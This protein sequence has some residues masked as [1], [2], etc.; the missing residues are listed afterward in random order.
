VFLPDT[1]STSGAK[2]SLVQLAGSPVLL[3]QEQPFVWPVKGTSRVAVVATARAAHAGQER[4][5]RDRLLYVAM[6]RA[7]DR[8]YVAGFEGAR[9]RNEGCWYDLIWDG[10]H[11]ALTETIGAD[12]GKV[13]RCVGQQSEAP[14][15]RT[16]DDL[17]E[18]NAA[19]VLPDWARR[20]APRDADRGT[21]VSPSRLARYD[22]PGSP[23]RRR[24]AR[25][26]SGAELDLASS[27]EELAVLR[28]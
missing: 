20:A 27:P 11:P 21:A 9:G 5:E 16:K 19:A 17:V 7:R 14:D 4:R 15:Q 25:D 12:G 6:T 23:L 2:A 24:G 10:L 28:G 3:D 22:L 13:W 18:R 1:C 8:L 26:S